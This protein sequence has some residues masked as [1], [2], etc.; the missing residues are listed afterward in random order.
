MAL[1][2]GL[3]IG[4]GTGGTSPFASFLKGGF[5]VPKVGLLVLTAF[6]PTGIA[7]LNLQATGNMFGMVAKVISYGLGILYAL[8]L[9]RVYPS[10]FSKVIMSLMF[11]GPWYIFDILGYLD[12]GFDK[13]GFQPPVPIQGYPKPAPPVQADGTWI[14]SPTLVSLII[15][16][17][18]A[19]SAALTSLINFYAPGTVGGNVQNYLGYATAGVGALG[20]ASTIFMASRGSGAPAPPMTGGALPSLSSFAKDLQRS[21][22]PQAF[23]E[24]TSFLGLL[25]FI[26]LGGLTLGAL[27]AKQEGGDT[28]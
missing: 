7:G 21:A 26:V 15:T 19:Y 28:V 16:M 13:L 11:L 9:N 3:P 2:T 22:S 25:V 14:L 24:S 1:P 10:I 17:L 8:R 4:L 27:R 12:P 18:P 23:Q 6:P 5:S 20:I